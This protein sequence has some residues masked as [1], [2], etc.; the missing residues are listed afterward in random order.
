MSRI[1]E[2]SKAV[3]SVAVIIAAFLVAAAM[4]WNEMQRHGD[5]DRD[6]RDIEDTTRPHMF[7]LTDE[8]LAYMAAAEEREQPCRQA[9]P[10][11]H[12]QKEVPHE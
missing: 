4:P 2:A 3:I 7:S 12:H 1:K 10:R 5:T 6:I 8:E 11:N 9:P